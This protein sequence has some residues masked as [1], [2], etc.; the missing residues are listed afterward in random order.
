MK[1][2]VTS[3]SLLF[4]LSPCPLIRVAT[5]EEKVHHQHAFV[6][7]SLIYRKQQH[8]FFLLPHVWDIKEPHASTCFRRSISFV[9]H[10]YV[11]YT[12]ISI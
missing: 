11:T 1:C 3:R 12:Y 5:S 10:V 6:L 4:H 9:F 7:L 2:C 8:F